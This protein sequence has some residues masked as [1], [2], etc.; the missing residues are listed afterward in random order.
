M[1]RLAVAAALLW[2]ACGSDP[3]PRGAAAPEVCRAL[4]AEAPPADA[5]LVLVVNDAMRRDRAG[6]YGGPA[7]TPHFDAFA[8]AHL[9]FEDAVAPAP[10]TK[11]S[12][13]TLFTS[14]H[15]SQ[16]GVTDP[17]RDHDADGNLVE[18]DPRTLGSA[19]VLGDG[20]D[21]LA[22]SLQR[23]GFRTGAFIANPWLADRFGF[24]QGFDRY[25]DSFARW[26]VPGQ[27]VV[28]GALTWLEGIP[29]DERFF[30]YVHLLDTHQPYGSLG[31]QDAVELAGPGG[32]GL[33]TEGRR[34][35]QRIW[36]RSGN[37][38][39]LGLEELSL[40]L[41]E[42][43]YDRGVERFDRAL[44]TLLAALEARPDWPR[45]AV[46]VTSD[47]GEALF[48]H[49]WGDHG[50]SLH[51]P[52][53]R[54][55]LAARLPG[56]APETCRVERPVGL[57]DL[58]PTVCDYLGVACPASF[59]GVSLLRDAPAAERRYV[60]SEHI[61]KGHRRRAIR[62]GRFKLV[63]RPDRE[64]DWLLYDLAR[65]PGE[66]HNLLESGGELAQEA[67]IP[68][69]ALET[70]VP[71]FTAPPPQRAPLDPAV[72]ERLRELGYLETPP[73]DTIR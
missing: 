71:A 4:R 34:L 62:D 51:E 72:A 35:L 9:L 47:H 42:R 27:E 60:V 67:A 10:W 41:L 69:E 13:A 19:D 40:A 17:V 45:T 32:P 7:T 48:E 65:D 21:T 15:P 44:G 53:L 37:E 66:T 57:I 31:E 1:R 3:D 39:I 36:A 29:A 5:S 68:R 33:P 18:V 6:V 56:V 26:D 12:V 16:H 25:E 23:A 64:V 11:P 43:A 22:E 63:H 73:P 28:H 2:T 59:H 30:L 38:R 49:G 50:R 8:R 52:E 24:D 54:I 20:F 70:A 46:W 61:L 55:P 14:L 58:A